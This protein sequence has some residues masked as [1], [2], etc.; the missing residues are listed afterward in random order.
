MTK[1]QK[2]IILIIFLLAIIL[3]FNREETQHDL[4]VAIG[5][6]LELIIIK[7]TQGFSTQF[8]DNLKEF[9]TVKINPSPQPEA[10]LKFM[11]VEEVNFK[12]V[13]KRHQ[14]LL[15]VSKSKNFSISIKNDVFAIG[16][17]VIFLECP[18]SILL[19]KKKQEII[20]L[21]SEIKKTEINRMIKDIQANPNKETQ[22]TIS[23]KH[24]ISLLLPKD[25]FLAYSNHSVTWSRRETTKISQGILIA[26]LDLAIDP[27]DSNAIIS[28]IDSLTKEHIFGPTENSHM[29]TEKEAPVIMDSI[30]INNLPVLRIKS[31]WRM[32]N[33]FMGGVYNAYYFNIDPKQSPK[34]I[35]TYLYA[36]GEKKNIFLLQLEAIIN[37][38]SKK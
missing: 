17:Q 25:F 9:L 8:Y 35:Y 20:G 23:Q 14:N 1:N 6:P 21:V 13:L 15:V 5:E 4:P 28:I 2:Y 27:P 22:H 37:T 33:D 19:K 30:V 26:N 7:N 36:P 12:G 38:L 29:I 31:L 32:E 10:V 34:I 16:Q 3:F 11:E 24:G 18:S